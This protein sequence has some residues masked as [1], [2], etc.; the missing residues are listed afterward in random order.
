MDKIMRYLYNIFEYFNNI[1]IK[2]DNNI[3]KK[4][5]NNKQNIKIKEPPKKISKKRKKNNLKNDY[6]ELYSSN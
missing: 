5:D 3:N 2:N 1:Y 4:N 6:Q